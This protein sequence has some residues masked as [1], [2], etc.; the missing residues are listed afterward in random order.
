V[1]VLGLNYLTVFVFALGF[2][3]LVNYIIDFRS[4]FWSTL[5]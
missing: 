1:V 5:L 3:D 4:L 2:G